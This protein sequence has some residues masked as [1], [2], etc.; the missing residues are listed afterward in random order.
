VSRW[1]SGRI[2]ILR[3]S[4]QWWRTLTGSAQIQVFVSIHPADCSLPPAMLSDINNPTTT[5]ILAECT[6]AATI[7]QTAKHVETSV[8]FF[9]ML[10]SHYINIQKILT[11]RLLCRWR[12]TSWEPLLFLTIVMLTHSV[13]KLQHLIWNRLF[14]VLMILSW[15]R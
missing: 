4:I 9:L 10:I 3:V 14:L 7:V 6:V 2:R 12:H 5:K 8:F 15:R 11:L 13:T 1:C